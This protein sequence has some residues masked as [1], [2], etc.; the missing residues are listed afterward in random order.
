MVAVANAAGIWHS[1]GYNF[2]DPNGCVQELSSAT[3]EHLDSIPPFITEW[4]AKDIRENDFDGYYQNPV[5]SVTMNIY[6]TAN[7]IYIATTG[8]TNLANVHTSAG[9]L[10]GNAQTFLTH[11]SK[12]SGLIEY[13]GSDNLTPYLQ[14]A[15]SAGRTAMYITNQTDGITN[16]APMLGCFSCLLIEPQLISNTTT[17]ITYSN[18]ISGSIYLGSSTL[19]GSEITEI[20][21]H[22]KNLNNFMS[23]RLNSDLNFYSNIKRL[24]DGYNKTKKLNAVG[25]TESYLINNLIGTAKAKA[26]LN[27]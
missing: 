21:T 8:V 26:R 22:I 9:I 6:N 10:M 19:T 16:N 23:Y 2:D 17:L 14:P 12:Q 13:D 24:I 11:T 20:D 15:L 18:D 4:M 7:A 27:S 5:Q 1:F 25:E 3:K